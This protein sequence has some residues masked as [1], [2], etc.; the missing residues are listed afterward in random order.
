VVILHPV[1]LLCGWLPCSLLSFYCCGF[2]G[3]VGWLVWSCTCIGLVGGWG[4]LFIACYGGIGK[5]VSN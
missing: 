4:G 1:P 3:V 2:G 5:E